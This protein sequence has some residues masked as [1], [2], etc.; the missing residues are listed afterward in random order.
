VRGIEEIIAAGAAKKADV[1]ATSRAATRAVKDAE[2]MVTRGV[3]KECC[4]ALLQ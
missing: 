3:D 4:S 1:L 2:T